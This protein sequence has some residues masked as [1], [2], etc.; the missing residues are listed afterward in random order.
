MT[1]TP[2]EPLGNI[3]VSHQPTNYGVEGSI[4]LVNAPEDIHYLIASELMKNSP[5]AVLALSQSSARLRRATMS[6]VYKDLILRNGLN[7]AKVLRA[8][9][10][11]VE[12]FRG[13]D[14]CDVA[15][16]V[17]TIT[18]RDEIPTEDFILILDKIAECGTLRKLRYVKIE[19]GIFIYH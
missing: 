18:V 2:E 17:R 7:D 4:G 19:R 13:K 15:K 11:L 9:T 1:K 14:G 10:A 5:S 3:L 16:H 12:T 6:F 8:Y